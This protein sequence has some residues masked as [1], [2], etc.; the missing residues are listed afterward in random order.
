MSGF[1]GIISNENIEERRLDY[2]T[3]TINLSQNLSTKILRKDNT[4]FVTSHLKNTPLIVSK[5][6]NF[7]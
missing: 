6:G 1:L 4:I 7:W 3:E 5:N 2:L